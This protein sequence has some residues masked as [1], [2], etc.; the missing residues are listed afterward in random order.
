MGR[1]VVEQ[2]VL[3]M[4]RQGKVIAGAKVLVLGLSFK[5]NCPDLRN[6]RVVDLIEAPSATAWRQCW[7]T[8]RIDPAEAQQE[9]GLTVSSTMPAKERFVAVVA[10]VSHREFA[11]WT[12]D[13]WREL[14]LPSGLL[15][16]LKGIVPRE[17]APLRL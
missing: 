4:A 11:Q 7:W 12:P 17:L 2:L 6:T 13:Q 8:L 10:A 5:E 16:D 3:E 15:L 9:H 1:W 14:L